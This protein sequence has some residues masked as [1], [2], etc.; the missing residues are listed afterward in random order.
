MMQPLRKK[1]NIL[2]CQHQSNH[3]KQ[4]YYLFYL[5][6]F[7]PSLQPSGTQIPGPLVRREAQG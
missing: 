6:A 1:K 3:Q 5:Q 4:Y 7:Y 2:I